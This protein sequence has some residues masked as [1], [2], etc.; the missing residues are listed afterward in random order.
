MICYDDDMMEK[1]NLM[2]IPSAEDSI[3]KHNTERVKD[4]YQKNLRIGSMLR[5]NDMFDDDDNDDAERFMIMWDSP[6]PI[7]NAMV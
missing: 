4:F 2:I 1:D 5:C 6:I 3:L 7:P